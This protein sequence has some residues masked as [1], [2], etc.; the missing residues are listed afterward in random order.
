M[1]GAF[2][3]FTTKDLMTKELASVEKHLHRSNVKNNV[4]QI[5]SDKVSKPGGQGVLGDVPV[6]CSLKI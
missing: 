2:N 5:G 1:T 3:L 6:G 4:T